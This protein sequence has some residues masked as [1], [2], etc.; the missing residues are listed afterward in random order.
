[1]CHHR[2]ITLSFLLLRSQRIS[3]FA[4]RSLKSLKRNRNGSRVRINTRF[5]TQSTSSIRGNFFNYA[6]GHGNNDT[7]SETADATS[8]KTNSKCDR[9]EVTEIDSS[10]LQ[11]QDKI[12]RQQQYEHRLFG[13]FRIPASHIFNKSATLLTFALVN[14]RPIVPGHVLVVPTRVVSRLSELTNDEHDDLWRTVRTVQ[15]AL[16]MAYHHSTSDGGDGFNV[17]VQDGVAAG[18][19]VP[20]VHV[21]ILPR[22]AGDFVRN[23]DVYDALDDWAPTDLAAAKKRVGGMVKI[24]VSDD[25]RKDRSMEDMKAEAD[26]YKHLLVND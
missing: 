25:D 5:L 9:S 14:L 26:M 21:H 17:A 16:G 15:A 1:M 7:G 23:D 20:H 2:L 24:D 3:T 4:C 22:V 18:Q 8:K 12:H 11:Q 6:M 19:S 13:K 10:Q